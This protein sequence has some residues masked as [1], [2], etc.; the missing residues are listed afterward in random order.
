MIDAVVFDFDGLILDTE[1]ADFA[2]WE[3]I[4][5]E[6]GGHFGLEDFLPL[7]GTNSDYDPVAEIERQTGKTLDRAAVMERSWVLVREAMSSEPMRPG[8]DAALGEVRAA[9]WRCGLASSS[10]RRWVDRLMEPLGIANRFDVIRCR[11]DVERVKPAPDLYLSALEALGVEAARSLALEDSPNG[12]RA[13]KA[14]G[15]WCV[16]IPAPMTQTLD[17]SEADLVVDSLA[18]VTIAELVVRLNP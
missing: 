17:L 11:D 8:I 15:M 1:S 6:Y 5:A 10:S 9:G 4:F 16:A 18:D 3:R 12:V 2:A 7:I 13:A 14:A